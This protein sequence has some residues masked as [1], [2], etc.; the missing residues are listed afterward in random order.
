MHAEL[1]FS[2]VH[3]FEEVVPF[4]RKPALLPEKR[5]G[6]VNRE[7]VDELSQRVIEHVN[8]AMTSLNH[9]IGYR[10]G[11]YQALARSGAST[12]EELAEGTGLRER[13]VRE[14]LSC[15]AAGRYVDYD[16]E[17][18][19]FS[20]SAEQA[21]VL[22]DEG[23][24][25]YTIPFVAYI[26]S[27]AS[28]LGNVMEAFRTGSGVPYREYGADMVEAQGMGYRPMYVSRLVGDWI[29]AIPDVERRLR[30]RG[31][32]A[33]VGCGMGWASIALA[34]GF[35]QVSID[36]VDP[37]EVSIAEA[38]RHAQEAGVS[39]RI[40]FHEASIE[41]APLQGPYD[42]VTAFEVLHDLAYPVRALRRMK[43]LASPSGTVLIADEAVGDSLEENCH[44]LGHLYYNFSV[45]HCLPQS[46]AFPDSAATGTVMTPSTLRRYA[47]EAGF[48]TV[49]ILPIEN[50]MFRFY[51]LTP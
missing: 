17:R 45:L 44:F 51:R 24:P 40:R 42:L 19:R 50:P 22:V 29:P 11:L 15:M 8:G 9:Y 46:M 48:R 35:P 18:G 43:E 1:V 47:S 25:A 28:T 32:I 14:W 7:R 4:L 41:E 12:P 5:G 30:G 33:D 20:L 21:A 16:S 13:Y 26:P 31:R 2:S 49:D 10:L 34:K 39:D 27:F 3:H 6:A 37:D 23:D 38:R 36:A